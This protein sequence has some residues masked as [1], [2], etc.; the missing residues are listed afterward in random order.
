MRTSKP[1]AEILKRISVTIKTVSEILLLRGYTRCVT[2]SC[3][4]WIGQGQT[5][6]TP[7]P[8]GL[9]P[10]GLKCAPWRLLISIFSN[11]LGQNV[12]MLKM[13]TTDARLTT[14]VLRIRNNKCE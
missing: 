4:F 8:M 10:Y 9:K 5:C 3:L 7:Y 14:K 6:A 13:A 12:A 1:E 11:D 2:I